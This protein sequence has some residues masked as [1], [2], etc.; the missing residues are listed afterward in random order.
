MIPSTVAHVITIGQH[1]TPPIDAI[2]H[3]ALAPMA[4]PPTV[5]PAAPAVFAPGGLEGPGA[6]A[7]GDPHVQFRNEP[8]APADL[9]RGIE[10]IPLII[11]SK[12]RIKLRTRRPPSTSSRPEYSPD[13]SQRVDWQ[14]ITRVPR[15]S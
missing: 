14:C 8:A 1:P 5:A 15:V 11:S 12:N 4:V 2:V 13:R 7:T 6:G 10:D 3:E 9:R